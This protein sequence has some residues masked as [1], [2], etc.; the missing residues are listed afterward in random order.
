VD[1]VPVVARWVRATVDPQDPQGDELTC[2]D[3]FEIYAPQRAPGEPLPQVTFLNHS[4]LNRPVTK[5]TLG[6]VALTSRIEGDQEELDLVVTNTGAMTALFCVPHPL[7][8]YRTDLFVDNRNCS[9]PP[10]ESRTITI[11][12]K[13]PPAGGLTLFQT[14]WRISCWNADDVVIEPDASVL[15]AVGRR[16]QM[17]REYQGYAEPG[18]I[19]GTN[20]TLVK[21]SGQRADTSTMPFLLGV[22]GVAAW[23]FNVDPAHAGKPAHLVIHTADQS[24]DAP[25]AIQIRLND[26]SFQKTLPKGLGVQQRDPAHLAFPKALTLEVPAGVLRAGSNEIRVQCSSGWFTWDAMVLHSHAR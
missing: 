8:D 5:T 15:L 23:Q 14:G 4:G 6:V 17:C 18:A 22:D 24:A 3:E 2:I 7:I 20:P 19:D 11:R 1:V 9:V 26:S 12:A 21:A 10:G 25:A 16:D 13:R